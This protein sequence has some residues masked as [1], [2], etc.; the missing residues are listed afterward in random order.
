[1]DIR[2][3]LPLPCWLYALFQPSCTFY[4]RQWCWEQMVATEP[5]QNNWAQFPQTEW[6]K[7]SDSHTL[8]EKPIKTLHQYF[9]RILPP[10]HG[11]LGMGR[12]E[13]SIHCNSAIN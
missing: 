2:I 13:P 4:L 12:G 9:T 10:P 3:G 1:M 8:V 7:A 6:D 5:A 11:L